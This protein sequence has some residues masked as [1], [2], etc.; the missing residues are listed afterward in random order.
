M[1]KSNE[2]FAAYRSRSELGVWRLLFFNNN[3]TY[4]KG[5]FDYV[6]QTMI[7]FDLQKYFNEHYDSLRLVDGEIEKR[8]FMNFSIK[9]NGIDNLSRIESIP[10]F[11][12]Y[13]ENENHHCGKPYPNRDQDL[14]HFSDELKN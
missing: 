6:Q 12:L 7:H 8:K 11:N 9:Y 1:L 3:G 13:Y 14:K 2:T 4:H 10:I 5:R